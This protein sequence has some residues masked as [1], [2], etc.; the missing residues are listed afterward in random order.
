MCQK[1]QQKLFTRV[2][3]NKTG[4]LENRTAAE[5]R[6]CKNEDCRPVNDTV[7]I[8]TAIRFES[9]NVF[10]VVKNSGL[11]PNSNFCAVKEMERTNFLRMR[12]VASI[13]SSVTAYRVFE[14]GMHGH[15]ALPASGYE[16]IRNSS[17][18]N[19][20]HAKNSS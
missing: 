18:F 6:Q 12:L 8:G 15:F 3:I 14:C 2:D 20:R 13:K 5:A 16:V 10:L 9:T 11:N 7:D 1:R 17:S 19:K 4:R